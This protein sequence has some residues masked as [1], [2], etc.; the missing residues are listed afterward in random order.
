MKPTRQQRK[1]LKASFKASDLGSNPVIKAQNVAYGVAFRQ[2][3]R[4]H[5]NWNDIYR[6]F[7][8]SQLTTAGKSLLP[9]LP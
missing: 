8:T 9:K 1:E 7:R 6:H 5:S 3:T 4:W 2:L